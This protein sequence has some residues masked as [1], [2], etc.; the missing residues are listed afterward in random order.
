MA[1]PDANGLVHAVYQDSPLSCGTS[2]GIVDPST[3]APVTGQVQVALLSSLGVQLLTQ[4]DTITSTTTYDMNIPTGTVVVG[5]GIQVA[6]FGNAWL[7][8]DGPHPTDASKWRFQ[9]SVKQQSG[10]NGYSMD[11]TYWLIVVNAS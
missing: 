10:G 7:S 11:V 3:A 6:G 2:L 9:A 5:S 8:A 1:I 4:A